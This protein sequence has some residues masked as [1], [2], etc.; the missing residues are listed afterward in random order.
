MGIQNR[1]PCLYKRLQWY[2]IV[3]VHSQNMAREDSGR[4]RGFL[5]DVA[6]SHRSSRLAFHSERFWSNNDCV[7]DGLGFIVGH[8]NL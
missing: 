5:I 4:Q 2:S 8:T 1:S 6:D 7:I 3:F